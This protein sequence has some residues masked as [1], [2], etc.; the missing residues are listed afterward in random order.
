MKCDIVESVVGYNPANQTIHRRKLLY[1]NVLNHR[2]NTKHAP[3][4]SKPKPG[5]ICFSFGCSCKDE[6]KSIL[7]KENTMANHANWPETSLHRFKI[8]RSAEAMECSTGP[9]HVNLSLCFGPETARKPA[10][11]PRQGRCHRPNSGPIKNNFLTR[12]PN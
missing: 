6:F 8:T 12:A 7:S 10:A 2:G 1:K 9:S 3:A 11:E 5:Y 4:S